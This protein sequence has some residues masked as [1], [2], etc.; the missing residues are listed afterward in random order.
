[1]NLNLPFRNSHILIL[2][3]DV[4]II[5][6]PEELKAIALQVSFYSTDESINFNVI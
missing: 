4:D 5:F 1:M 2:L 3:S 6:E